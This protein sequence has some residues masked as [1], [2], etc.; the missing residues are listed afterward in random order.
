ME[1]TDEKPTYFYIHTLAVG[2]NGRLRLLKPDRIE[3]P[4][5][6]DNA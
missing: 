6:T 5:G 2:G 1:V 4:G 3:L